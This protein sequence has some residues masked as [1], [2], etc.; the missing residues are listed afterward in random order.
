MVHKASS[1]I[2]FMKCYQVIVFRGLTE[3]V[4]RQAERDEQ[5]RRPILPVLAPPSI[6][7]ITC[8]IRAHWEDK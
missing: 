4:S 2:V 1:D 7:D 5:R 8:R 6:G 3:V